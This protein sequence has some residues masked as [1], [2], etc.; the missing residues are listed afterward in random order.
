MSYEDYLNREEDW[1]SAKGSR[2]SSHKTPTDAAG[3]YAAGRYGQPGSASAGGY[4]SSSGYDVK[5]DTSPYTDAGWGPQG[6]VQVRDRP[7]GVSGPDHKDRVGQTTDRSAYEKE[8]RR[9]R[10]EE[11]ARQA[12]E[13]WDRSLR[14]AAAR[15]EAADSARGSKPRVR[16]HE[17]KDD[18]GGWG[19]DQGQP[20]Y[21]YAGGYG[22]Q[23]QHQQV[24]EQQER[25]ERKQQA[26][27]WLEVLGKVFAGG[28]S[29]AGAPD[30]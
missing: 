29:Y 28:P 18:A 27:D 21:A 23:Q 25:Q 8:Q 24:G 5:T 11:E 6:R 22:C 4:S 14:E 20:A 1:G 26:P 13:E 19:R 30:L 16:Y 2:D 10:Y 3:V 12:R 17:V 9:L 7:H 15:R